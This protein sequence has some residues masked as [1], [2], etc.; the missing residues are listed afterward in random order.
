MDG[1]HDHHGDRIAPEPPAA[2]RH[3]VPARLCGD[4]FVDLPAIT[5]DPAGEHHLATFYRGAA[6]R[7]LG[8]ERDASRRHPSADA[9]DRAD[10]ALASVLSLPFHF[11]SPD[12]P[13]DRAP[14]LRL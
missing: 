14:R 4:W 3:V 13:D 11:A 12:I 8:G 7:Y 10:R 5:A 2:P 6:V 1:R 9:A